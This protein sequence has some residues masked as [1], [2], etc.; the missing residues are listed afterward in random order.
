MEVN[1]QLHT[2]SALPQGKRLQDPLERRQ[3]T[4]I[5]TKFARKIICSTGG[6]N[7]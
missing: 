1:G 6:E 2:L 7:A 5:Y 3:F 4:Q